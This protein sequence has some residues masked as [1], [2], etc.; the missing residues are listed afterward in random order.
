MRKLTCPC[1]Q[2]FNIDL[3]EVVNLDLTPEII[4]NIKNGS[5]LACV[6]P[7]CNSILHTELKTRLEW[8]SKKINL[9]LLPEIERYNFL[10]G[11]IKSDSD[12]QVVIGFAE[13]ADRI[14]VISAGL[15]PLV[16]ESLKYHL[17]MKAQETS[18]NAKV[19][20]LFEKQNE[21]NDLEFHIHGLKP[22]EVAISVIPFRIYNSIQKEINE[23]IEKT[24]YK[25][26]TQGTYISVQNMLFEDLPH[27]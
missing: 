23:N 6:C 14:E 4:E 1:E 21:N 27:D 15:D 26:L 3:P 9:L 5:F 8:P 24:P 13:L 22:D 7:S 16:I 18:T 20:V 10:S 12:V 17:I 25:F 19:I 11:N 2:V